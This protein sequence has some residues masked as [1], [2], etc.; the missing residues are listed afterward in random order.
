MREVVTIEAIGHRGDG[1]ATTQDGPLYVPFALPG[2]RVEIERQGAGT[3]RARIVAILQ[4]SA[5][6]VAPLCRHFGT[7]GG[8]ALQM[9]PLEATHR[10]KRDFVVA[11]L[12]QRGLSPDVAET[13]GVPPAS[14]RR[15]VLTALR[16]GKNLILGYHERLSQS[17]VDIEEC[18]VLMPALAGRLG[19]I[20]R[21]A[22]PIVRG[23][24]PVR[25]TALL[26]RAG[27]DLNF[28]GTPPPEAR[29]V[30]KLAG[31][32]AEC[33]VARLSIDGE[34]IV[35]LAEPMLNI[36]DVALTPPPGVFVQASAEA[37]A[38]MTRLVAEH[39]AGAKRVADLFAG[40][41]T[42]SLALARFASIRAVEANAPALEAL[43][44]AFRNA[45]GLKP[46]ETERRDLFA[47][48][49]APKEL[50]N[51]TASSSTRLM[52]VQRRR[53]RPLP[54]RRS[55]GSPPFPATPPPSRATRASW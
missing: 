14:R 5:E 34:P 9:L 32:A 20:R 49:L 13:I 38:A 36:A 54:L 4:P 42:F 26:T 35:T 30:A 43:A 52:P 23:K 17:V 31:S 37:E 3:E 44:A 21:I 39:L 10:L 51:S 45:A 47:D 6:R 48:P 8:C 50:E 27:L 18:P 28:D 55:H 40:V 33:G 24:K 41:G 29:A 46:V 12:R 22:E 1:I 25:L 53:L 11:A 16:A 2:E 15:A 7:C 19:D